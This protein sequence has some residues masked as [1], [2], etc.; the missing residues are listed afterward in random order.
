LKANDED[1]RALRK[2]IDKMEAALESDPINSS[3]ASD[4]DEDFHLAFCR[5][6][7]NRILENI[8]QPIITH[9]MVRI[10][11]QIRGSRDFG[12]SAIRGHKEILE[13]VEKKDTKML[14][15]A[16]EEHLEM[17]FEGIDRN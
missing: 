15:D 4:A 11:K 16:V 10:W 12:R 6:A 17:V 13:G 9:A 14:V 7:H 1:F 3:L 5:A 8:A 2:G